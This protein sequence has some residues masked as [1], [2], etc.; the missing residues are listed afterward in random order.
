MKKLVVVVALV[1]ASRWTWS[2]ERQPTADYHARREKR[3]IVEEDERCGQCCCFRRWRAE[4]RTP[5]TASGRTT[6]SITT[7]RDGQNRSAALLIVPAA[8]AS[9]DA[10]SASLQRDS[11]PGGEQQGGREKKVDRAETERHRSASCQGNWIRS[12]GSDGQAA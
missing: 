1:F 5:Y 2:L 4:G 9:G 3:R 12:R 10:K 8:E 6:I 11:F 7:S